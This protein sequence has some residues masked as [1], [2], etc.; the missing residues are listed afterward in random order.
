MGECALA[1]P[2]RDTRGKAIDLRGRQRLKRAAL[3]VDAPLLRYPPAM[4]TLIAREVDNARPQ[5]DRSHHAG[6]WVA[7]G[8]ARRPGRVWFGTTRRTTKGRAI[9]WTL[10]DETAED[11]GPQPPSGTQPPEE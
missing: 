11:Q 3:P 10:I 2:P 6:R 4:V 8:G 5:V 9:T 1:W 7:F